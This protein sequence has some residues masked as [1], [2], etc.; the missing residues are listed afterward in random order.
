MHHC[1]VVFFLL[2][3]FSY[4]NMSMNFKNDIYRSAL[5]GRPSKS[6]FEKPLKIHPFIQNNQAGLVV[7]HSS[8]NHLLKV[9]SVENIGVEPMTSCVQGRRS[10]QLS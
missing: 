4:P 7:F 3:V 5:K 10:S 8:Q 6:H 2:F 1:I 9:L